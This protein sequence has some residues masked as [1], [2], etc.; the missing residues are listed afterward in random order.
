[1]IFIEIEEFTRN[2]RDLN[3]PDEVYRL[4]QIELAINPEKGEMIQGTGGLRKVRMRLPGRG[5][6]G[7]ARVLYVWLDSASRVILCTAYT[8]AKT[9][10]MSG[11]DKAEFKKLVKKLN[12]YYGRRT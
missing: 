1:M 9:E 7:S 4:F 8:K 5:K 2:L 12:D 10:N 3:I 11:A 6:S